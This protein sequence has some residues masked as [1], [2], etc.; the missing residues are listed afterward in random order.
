M[1]HSNEDQEDNSPRSSGDEIWVHSFNEE[2]AQRFREQ[3]M[4]RARRGPQLIIPIYIDSYGG[5]VDSLAKML[6]TMDEVPNRFITIAS[7]KAMS[8]GA[9]LLSHGDMRFVGRLSRVMIHNI[10]SGSWGDVHAM[11]ADS[12]ESMRLNK[13]FMKLLAENCGM[14]Y[15]DL[16]R[17]IKDTTDSKQIW[18]SPEDALKFGIV[19]HVG[20]PDIMPLL[21][22]SVQPLPKKPSIEEEMAELKKLQRPLKK[23]PRKPTRKKTR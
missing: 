6:E 3:V 5:Y 7:G 14:A 10:S 1:K 21:Q 17:K 18:L 9:I 11:K 8:C 15:E 12:E 16:Q 22:W 2:S 20:T 23:Q 19:D 13:I 4:E